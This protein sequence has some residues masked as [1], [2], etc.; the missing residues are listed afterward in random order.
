MDTNSSLLKSMRTMTEGVIS[1]APFDKTRKAQILLINSDNTCKIKM[2]GVEYPRVKVYG[3]VSGLTI[4]QIVRV[5]IPENQPSQ[6]FILS[7]IANVNDLGKFGIGTITPYAGKIGGNWDE[8]FP[9]PNGW[10]LCDGSAVS[11]TTFDKLFEVIGTTYGAGDGSTTFNLPNLSGRT[12]FGVDSGDA[13]F[14]LGDT[15]G[16]KT[17]TPNGTVGGHTLTTAEIPAHTHGSSGE[18]K[19]SIYYRNTLG[20]G[21]A[22]G[23]TSESFSTGTSSLAMETGGAHTHTSVGG[24]GSHNHPFTGTSQNTMPPYLTLNFIICYKPIGGNG[25]GGGTGGSASWGNIGGTLSEQTDLQNA[26]DGKQRLLES[27]NN[28][29]TINNQSILGTG[30]LIVDGDKA[31]LYT[32]SVPS[33]TWVITHNLNKYPS[34]TVT[35]SAGSIVVGEYTYLSTNQVQC[36]FSGEFSGKAC[37]N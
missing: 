35:D 14:D 2:D 8:D 33:D 28:I 13:D 21:S 23:L 1:S 37:L 36:S 24:G 9:P 16:S 29:K 30:N 34:I 20:T 6:M 25:G 17:H 4:N 10:L 18:H 19:H 5:I 11:R 32:Q 22:V 31:F 3:N 15:G 26:L 27:G 12:A 7:P